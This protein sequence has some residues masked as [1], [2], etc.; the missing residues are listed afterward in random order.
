MKS[1]LL[2]SILF[3][4][5]SSVFTSD[6]LAEEV[7]W[8]VYGNYS[9]ISLRDLTVALRNDGRDNLWKKIGGLENK[10]PAPEAAADPVLLT[11]E[12]ISALWVKTLI[13]LKNKD[14]YRIREAVTGY[15]NLR[16]N[17][18]Q[19]MPQRRSFAELSK[20]H[21][22]L[23]SSMDPVERAAA[24]NWLVS[25]AGRR[26]A[27]TDEK[28]AEYF[29]AA[30]KV[31]AGVAAGRMDVSTQGKMGLKK[32]LSSLNRDAMATAM[33]IGVSHALLENVCQAAEVFAGSEDDLFQMRGNFSKGT[34]M[35]IKEWAA[36]LSELMTPLDILPGRGWEKDALF[37]PKAAFILAVRY[38]IAF[39]DLEKAAN[40]DPCFAAFYYA[41]ARR[42][43]PAGDRPLITNPLG[44]GWLVA[45]SRVQKG[46][47]ARYAR[48]ISVSG[49]RFGDLLA[50]ALNG[51]E[52]LLMG[53]ASQ[54]D[55]SSRV[56]RDY[57]T[58]TVSSSTVVIDHGKQKP[59][60]AS[61][62]AAESRQGLTFIDL[63]GSGAYEKMKSYR[64]TLFMTDA[65]FLDVF[66]LAS[67][68]PFIAEWVME[69]EKGGALTLKGTTAPEMSYEIKDIAKSFLG[70]AWRE[71]A[72]RL[73]EDVS[74]QL[75]NAQWSCDYGN[76]LKTI[77]LGQ[78]DTRVLTGSGGGA[79][80]RKGE[81]THYRKTDQSFLIARRQNV[82]ETRFAALHE[83][84]EDSPKVRSFMRLEVAGEALV[85]EISCGEYLDYVVLNFGKVPFSFNISEKKI[86]KTDA[87]PCAFLRLHQKQGILLQNMN[88][89]LV[90][91]ND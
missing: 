91:E 65:Y 43:A 23:R 15:R 19:Y 1:R 78:S 48:L 70:S 68:E 25:M 9:L 35:V 21:A 89:E 5:L 59:A 53:R 12:K 51:G 26:E 45:R 4:F 76:G 27:D 36:K 79:I 83:I 56:G 13:G 87:S 72:Y 66:T 69:M 71:E 85:F 81:I 24:D 7:L 33:E 58:H 16:L 88:A 90:V 29:S 6:A 74:S 39:I 8:P 46:L 40:H 17:Y 10:K 14:V 18:P 22:A 41:R 20:I 38:G 31:F 52:K 64:R 55:G 30:Y 82:K 67:E 61:V 28:A 44:T 80:L 77:M 50:L 54:Q 37:S 84:Y 75:A 42:A 57:F 73:M 86:I 47:E 63:E 11:E 62:L 3:F 49:G 32:F 2:F 34:G 60:A